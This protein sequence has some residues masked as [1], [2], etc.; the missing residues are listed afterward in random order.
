MH[1]PLRKPTNHGGTRTRSKNSPPCAPWLRGSRV[2]TIRIHTILGELRLDSGRCYR[3]TVLIGVRALIRALFL[4][5][6]CA[7]TA[8]GQVA[9]GSLT[10]TVRDQ[11]GAAVPGVTIT[12]TNLATNRQRVARSTTDGVYAATS[13]PPG[14]Y[15]LDAA[16]QGVKSVAR[17]GVRVATGDVSR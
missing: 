16:L 13:L 10:G 11:T 2:S 14:A 7:A 1:D 12:I 4:V 9:S 15:R 8:R 5:L 3:H 6:V 17:D